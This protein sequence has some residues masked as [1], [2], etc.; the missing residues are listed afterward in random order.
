MN[1]RVTGL[2]NRSAFYAYLGR[3][4]KAAHPPDQAVSVVFLDLDDFKSLNETFGRQIGDAVLKAVGDRLTAAIRVPDMVSRMGND[5]FGCLITGMPIEDP[6]CATARTLLAAVSDPMII[7]SIEFTVRAS[8]GFA[9]HTA[10]GSGANALMER[11]ARA[12]Y[13]A[14]LDQSGY[15]LFKCVRSKAEQQR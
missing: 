13:R 6:L 3:A 8:M 14:K 2:P 5:E 15:A 11:A 4:L 7:G 10:D 12:M 9:T 1:D